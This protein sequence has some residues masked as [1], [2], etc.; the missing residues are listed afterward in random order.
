MFYCVTFFE[1]LV[2]LNYKDNRYNKYIET[3]ALF[4]LV[5]S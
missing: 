4:A 2:H 5:L 1:G 3:L